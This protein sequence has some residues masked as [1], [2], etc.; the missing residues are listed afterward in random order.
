MTFCLP[1]PPYL[2]KNYDPLTNFPFFSKPT[3]TPLT[4]SPIR[5]LLKICRALFTVCRWRD[6]YLCECIVNAKPLEGMNLL[7]TPDNKKDI[8]AIDPLQSDWRLHDAYIRWRSASLKN[9]RLLE[10]MY[11]SVNNPLSYEF[12]LSSGEKKA[13]K[14]RPELLLK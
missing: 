13:W 6:R 8:T 2:H 4:L 11:F 5:Q 7:L 10:Q 9:N 3:P 14:L 12:Y 1:H